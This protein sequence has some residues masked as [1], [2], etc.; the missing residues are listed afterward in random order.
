MRGC[1]VENCRARHTATP[2]ERMPGLQ[3]G[4]D[5]MHTE[6]SGMGLF[7]FGC[8][9]VY[10][11]AVVAGPAG[12][13]LGGKGLMSRPHSKHGHAAAMGRP[14]TPLVN[15]YY[16]GL[17]DTW[18]HPSVTL[19]P[20]AAA[21]SPQPGGCV[22]GAKRAAPVAASQLPLTCASRCRHP[23]RPR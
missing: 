21:R 20:A 6:E 23:A 1:K 7:G 22:A 11:Q 5:H 16:A 2:A 15:C 18:M 12:H 14:S 19:H 8:P 13:P 17:L 3:H 9:H 10:G 4:L